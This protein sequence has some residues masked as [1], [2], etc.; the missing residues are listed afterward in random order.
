MQIH[1]NDQS[2]FV[3]WKNPVRT[4]QPLRKAVATYFEGFFG[5]EVGSCRLYLRSF[6]WKADEVNEIMNGMEST[7]TE[8]SWLLSLPIQEL[9]IL[10]LQQ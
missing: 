6:L 4:Y 3:Q 1:Q 5:E 7:W 10:T 2:Q 9:E 8:K